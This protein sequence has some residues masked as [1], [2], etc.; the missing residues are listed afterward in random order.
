MADL[1][2]RDLT[3]SYGCGIDPIYLFQVRKEMFVFVDPSGIRWSTRIALEGADGSMWP[4][5]S[6]HLTEE[7]S[8]AGQDL[9]GTF[10]EQREVFQT[11]GWEAVRTLRQYPGATGVRLQVRRLG[12]SSIPLR[13]MAVLTGPLEASSPI[14]AWRLYRNGFH[15]WS[16]SG[17]TPVVAPDFGTL[18]GPLGA[19]M[20]FDIAT[21]PGP[22]GV[23]RS[24]LVAALVIGERALILGQLT[25]ADQF[26]KIE[27]DLQGAPQ[28][29]VYAALDGVP[30]APGEE[31]A[32]EW[33]WVEWRD[34]ADPDPFGGYAE[35]VARAMRPRTGALAPSGWCSW[36]FYYTGVRADD[37][38]A[39][40]EAL[41]A[42]RP[43]LPV[44]LIQIDDGFQAAVGDW[45]R[46]R[47][48]FPD[49]VGPL[50]QAIREAGFI[51]GLWL[52]P[53]L[54]WPEARVAREHPDWLLRDA[55][56]RPVSA[57]FNWY[58]WLRA[59]DPTHPGVEEWLRELIHTVVHRWGF[60]YLKLDFLY[61]AALPGR[62]YDPKATRAQALRRGL[63]T[64]REAAG[65]ET[66]LLG[67]GCPLGPAIGLVDGMRIGPDV[68]P[69][70]APRMFG[71]SFPFRHE[72]SLP[73]ARNAMRNALARAWMHRRWWWNDPDCLLL[74]SEDT[75]LSEEEI[76]LLITV[77][78]MS[79][80]MVLD[81][82]PVFAL[83]PERLALW[84]ALLPPHGRRPEVLD[85]LE[86]EFPRILRL[87]ANMAGPPVVWIGLLNPED[88]PCH[89]ELPLQALGL[90]ETAW[91]FEFWSRLVQRLEGK[92]PVALPPHGAALWT[93]RP[94]QARF[95]WLGSTFR[96]PPG[97]EIIELEEA[98]HRGRWEFL[99]EPQ[100]EGTVW[101]YSP[102]ADPDI[103]W[104]GKQVSATP[105]GSGIYQ[106]TIPFQGR[107]CLEAWNPAQ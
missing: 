84:S 72:R 31:I 53:F 94:I 42:R 25:T 86:R 65:E 81:S 100:T 16:F 62:R 3:A 69:H 12:T 93:L 21:P 38:L 28:L 48:R 92:L 71:L 90:P 104:N 9:H 7:S 29:H 41:R 76:R 8:T 88:R 96:L 40:L 83:K 73:A 22:R 18:W 4:P 13:R 55:R 85:L 75:L 5:S 58:R 56:G 78:A 52:A 101:I 98:E 23:R 17:T 1:S 74:R 61:A 89:L 57:G 43:Q 68:A 60:P 10:R 33:I 67:C 15:S 30:I 80:G 36:Y 79:G 107:G 77:V 99:R 103:R 105:V 24:D 35:A 34:A 63:Q 95:Q 11:E 97:M 59:L 19:P 27:L 39:N 66:F 51:P 45:T 20:T 70:W 49:G 14:P 44:D 2:A 106:M 32:S 54:A 46:F 47:S 26:V 64:I 87:Q 50:A 102:I 6:W 82:D 91:G 37:I